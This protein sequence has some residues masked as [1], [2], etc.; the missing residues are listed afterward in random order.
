MGW[1]NGVRSASSVPSSNLRNLMCW[2]RHEIAQSVTGTCS[3][4]ASSRFVWLASPF[5][6]S[7]NQQLCRTEFDAKFLRAWCWAILYCI[8]IVTCP[9]ALFPLIVWRLP[10]FDRLLWATLIVKPNWCAKSVTFFW[11]RSETNREKRSSIVLWVAE[12]NIVCLHC[13]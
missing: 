12:K 5:Q 3:F 13:L 8:I 9:F 7:L 10:C 4:S 1:S 6:S 2:S 11:L